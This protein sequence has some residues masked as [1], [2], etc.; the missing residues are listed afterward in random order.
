MSLNLNQ[1]GLIIVT[2]SMGS[3]KSY[4]VKYIVYNNRDYFDYGIVF[5]Q[6]AFND[7]NFEYIPKNYI[8]SSYNPQKLKNLMILQKKQPESQRKRAFVILDDCVFDSWVYCKHF[9]QLITQVR[10][11]N[12]L[13]IITTQYINKVTPVI[14]EN[15]FQV[16]IFH[17]DIE[18]S[19]KALYESYGQMFNDYNTFKKWLMDNTGEHKFIWYNRKENKKE[20]RYKIMRCPENIPRFKLNY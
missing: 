6:T 8:Y 10:H 14:R 3:G 17:S 9:N 2:A 18:R 19:L 13:V 15:A 5:S 12:V 7:C 16:A 20:N 1:T 4:L 11:Y